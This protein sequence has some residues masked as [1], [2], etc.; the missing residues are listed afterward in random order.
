MSTPKHIPVGVWAKQLMGEHAPNPITLARWCNF[1]KI[2][3]QPE[4][5]G[6]NWFVRQDAKYCK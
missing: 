3:P 2:Q 5:I 6:R 4:K 1:G